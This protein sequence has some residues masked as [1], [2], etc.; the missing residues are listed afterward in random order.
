[1]QRFN[2]YLANKM[3]TV[4]GSM[5]FFYFCVVLDLIELPPVIK[6]HN[7][8]TWVAYL[9]QTVIQLIALPTL[10]AYQNLHASSMDSL[11]SKID[12]VHDHLGISKQGDK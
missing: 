1:M 11:H 4:L 5:Y 10:Q 7:T 12:A 8:I 9:S 6:A 2:D 3:G